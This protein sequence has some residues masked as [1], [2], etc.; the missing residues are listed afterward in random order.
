MSTLEAI[1]TDATSTL[2]A[3]TS[4][5]ELEQ[6]KA[7]YLGKTGSLTEHLKQLASLR[8]RKSVV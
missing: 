3:V 1:L 8:D 7:R 6:V 5:P 2:G 4:M